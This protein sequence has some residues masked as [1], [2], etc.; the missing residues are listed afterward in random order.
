MHQAGSVEK[1][2]LN[3]PPQ[4]RPP[5][6][7]CTL[8][9]NT[10]NL[11]KRLGYSAGTA[12]T[13]QARLCFPLSQAGEVEPRACLFSA[14]RSDENSPLPAKTC[15]TLQEEQLF[16]RKHGCV[17]ST[18]LPGTSS[19]DVQVWLPGMESMELWRARGGEP[20]P[21]PTRSPAV[22]PVPPPPD[23]LTRACP[24]H[25]AADSIA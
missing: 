10:F 23:G 22:S 9:D 20:K 15:Q 12:P 11:A 24:V 5:G 8:K 4:P 2:P 3:Q 13:G 21:C 7:L 6:A 18:T 17:L 1:R 25:T 19:G 14:E 16:L